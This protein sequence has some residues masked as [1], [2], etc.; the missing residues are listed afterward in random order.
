M[1]RMPS[2]VALAGGT[3]LKAMKDAEEVL[4]VAADHVLG[5]MGCALCKVKAARYL[6]KI[7]IGLPMSL[8]SAEA[9]FLCV[10]FSGYSAKVCAGVIGQWQV[11]GQ[12]HRSVTGQIGQWQVSGRSDMGRSM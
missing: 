9:R 1:R 4:V 11:S 5:K 6:F 8:V 7:R 2:L 12:G 3:Y 10:V